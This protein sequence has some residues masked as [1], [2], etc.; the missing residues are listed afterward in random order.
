VS[1]DLVRR[2]AWTPPAE[3]DVE[4][5]ALALRTGGA[6][7]WQVSLVAPSLVEALAATA[8]TVAEDTAARVETTI[9]GVV[10]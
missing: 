5:V 10:R 4:H 7:P 8:D 9:D 6:R 3:P 2:L 1:P